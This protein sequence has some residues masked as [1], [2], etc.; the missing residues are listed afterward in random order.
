EKKQ[1][2]MISDD[3]AYQKL[4][5]LIGK[6]TVTAEGKEKPLTGDEKNKLL[7]ELGQLYRTHQFEEKV[8]YSKVR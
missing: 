1:S 4:L 8:A 5:E 2:M 7:A 3:V 6:G